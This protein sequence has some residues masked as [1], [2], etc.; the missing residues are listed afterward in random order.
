M[1]PRVLIIGV[2]PKVVDPSDPAIPPGT[3]PKS[4][5]EGIAQTLAD[6]H[7]RGWQ[8]EH[9]A[10]MPDDSAEATM[11]DCLA[12]QDWDCVVIGGGVR[13]PPQRLELFE[14]VVNAIRHGAPTASIAFN[15]TPTDSADAAERWLRGGGGGRMTPS[16]VPLLSGT[17]T[18]L[19]E[20][21]GDG[22]AVLLLHGGAGPAMMQQLLALLKDHHVVLPTHP[23][24][25]GTERPGW[26]ASIS[27]LALCYLALL[28]A[29]EL[30]GVTVVGNSAG[31]WIGSEMATRR[32][33]AIARLLLLNAVGIKPTE[34]TGPI[35]NP[36]EIPAQRLAELA[37]A[38]PT[39]LGSPDP[40]AAQR[41]R[42]NQRVLNVYAG[43]H[44]MHDPSLG[45][46][47]AEIAIPTSVLWGDCDRIV[48]PAYGEAFARAIP[49]ASFGLIA[50]A[51]HMPQ[52][53]QP[54]AIAEVIRAAAW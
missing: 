23:G 1:T 29:L 54:Q 25:D 38:D 42:A 52:M 39:K 20:R 41:V 4:I 47:L 27:D 9:C 13:L 43:N 48:L 18:P 3:T 32:P 28:D 31:G 6:M 5:A 34:T 51:G 53:E 21:V 11:T 22:P 8:A 7:R 15:H 49:N 35:L 16:T 46:R 33:R 24:F 36:L 14:R 12:K 45:G 17:V 30:E 40:E 2:D 37:F 10:I 50:N 44:F 19:V 26:L